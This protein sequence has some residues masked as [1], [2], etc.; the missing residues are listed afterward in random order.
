MQNKGFI[1]VFS[2]ILTAIC[3]FYLSFSVVGHIYNR[4]AAEFAQGDLALR[5]QF[6][7]SLSTERVFLNYTLKQV[8]ERE[9]GLGLDLKGGM[10]A[11]LEVDAAQVVSS[12]ANTDDPNFTQALRATVQQ[13]RRGSSQDF[14]SLFQ[15]NYEQ[16]APGGRLANIFSITMS[17]RVPPTA[18]N[19]E[20]ISV[21]R[22][23]LRSAADNSFNVLTTRID[24]FG[25][26]A[27][28]IQR[29]DRAERILVE[30]PG[31]TEPERVRN[32]LQGSANLEFWKTYNVSEL[33]TALNEVNIRS[34][35]Y[36]MMRRMGTAGNMVA[37]EDSLGVVVPELV[38]EDEN[39]VVEI[40]R[41]LFEYFA[42]GGGGAVVGAVSRTDTAAVNFLLNR[43]RDVFPPDARFKW[44]FKPIDQRE[45]FFELF[46]L[47]GDGSR[48]GPALDGDAITSARADQGQQGSAWEVSMTM[49]S[50]GA[51]RWATI[52]GAEVGR[53]IA[54][55][56]DNYV[57]SAPMV[58]QRIDGGRSSISGNFSA[59]EAQDLENVLRSGRMQA[60]V[61]IVQEDIV[62]PSL[63]QEAI[64]D[65][66]I[67]FVIALIVMFIF[68]ILVYGIIP[69]LVTNGALLVN[70]FFI[71]GALSA[72]QAVLTLPGIAGMI[73]SLAMAVD[74]NI[75]INERIK[76]ELKAGKA[77]RRAVEDGYKNAFSAIF[78]A[79]L[80]SI[81]IGMI[82]YWF[83]TGPIKGFA[84]TLMV[85]VASSFITAVF[86]TRLV[87]ENRFE[88][89]KWLNITFKGVLTKVFDRDY[90]FNFINKGQIINISIVGFI[91]VC[92]ISLFSLGLNRGID[93]TGGRNYVVRFEQPV[94]TGEIQQALVPQFGE[95]VRVITIGS[96]SQ[97]RVSTN[98]MI[99]SDDE[100]VDEQMIALLGE[101][102]RNYIPAGK[103]IDDL[104]QSSQKVGPSIAED[105]LRNSFL[106][107]FGALICM[108]LY[109]LFRF[110]NWAFS[111]GTV[112]ALAVDAF[113]VLGLYSLLWRIMPF[114]M[115]VDQAFIAAIL[116]VIG[117]SINDKVVIFD[118]VRE[119]INLYP[120][121]TLVQQF[122]D[123]L[124]TTLTRTINTNLSTLLVILCVL[125]FGGDVVRSFIFA[126][127]I[128]VIIGTFSSLF[129]A[130]PVA[131]TV[132]NWQEGRKKQVSAK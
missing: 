99:D 26:V 128:G 130:S 102:L 5:N 18:T 108:G 3:L 63:G 122:N 111:A 37:D 15:Q 126:M 34:A 88:A 19:N 95:S 117:Y 53:P 20:V 41:S 65:G 76:E 80:T 105:L 93:F 124:N 28:N 25:V 116:T 46:A 87:Y 17:D 125:I 123:A 112:V 120:K 59:Q 12:L 104:I 54:I 32:L 43:Y 38:F 9:I 71:L 27:P 66:F 107:L 8:R 47:R 127:F 109:I 91:L 49:N 98:F 84:F 89:G 79:N 35:E 132:L 62:G 67:S 10:T 64:R 56:L 55:V 94:S 48:R 1:K 45:M 74:A 115:E 119:F 92:V 100:N 4:K 52:T 106:A 58:N 51:A 72:F 69:G 30:L 131:Y 13:N 75:L 16:I 113:I 85:G 78:D 77:L 68:I 97:V 36:A 118:R 101:G 114:S 90:N 129:I 57:Y 73:L 33:S 44:G 29:L 24:R 40:D 14:I 6:L 70:L 21:L 103:T 81:I 39:N 2:I 121:R 31:V 42:S 61:R 50:T 86:L 110:R 83:G 11:I 22:N 7:D 96:S 60:G 23:E 82:L